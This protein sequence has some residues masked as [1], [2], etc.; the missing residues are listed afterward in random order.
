MKHSKLLLALALLAALGGGCKKKKD[1]NATSQPTGKPTT[2]QP[3]SVASNT[4]PVERDPALPKGLP[5]KLNKP[6]PNSQPT[7]PPEPPK[8]EPPKEP[9]KPAISQADLDASK[10]FTEEGYAALANLE[11][12]KALGLFDQALKKN[13]GNSDA[14]AG[15]GLAKRRAGDLPGAE[16]AFRAA[17]SQNSA[18][19]KALAGLVQV[20]VEQGQ[21]E[22]AVTA[23]Q[24]SVKRNPTDPE[25]LSILAGAEVSAGKLVDAQE[26]SRQALKFDERH[27]NARISLARAYLALTKDEIAIA[28]LQSARDINASNAAVW[29]YL[30]VA[31]MRLKKEVDALESFRK[32]TELD[33]NLPEA[34]ANYGARLIVVEDFN[35]AV[36]VLER[37]MLLSP[38][39]AIASLNLGSAYRGAG[40]FG[41]AENAYKKAIRL[42]PSLPEAYFNLAV[43]YLEH[44]VPSFD[45]NAVGRLEQSLAQFEAYKQAY[46]TALPKDDPTDAYIE[47]AQ[48][49]LKIEQKKKAKDPNKTLQTPTGTG[50]TPTGPSG[51]GKTGPT[52][53]SG[54]SGPSGSGTTTT[55][56]PTSTPSGPSG[57]G[58]KN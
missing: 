35:N 44:P 13:P 9:P 42:N 20:L 16:S 2:S 15:V 26:H 18:A 56:P 17:L 21:S 41:P 46:K 36:L 29:F 23:A 54:P 10:R 12:Q 19:S 38:K 11:E 3:T 47:L 33:R 28:V 58:K 49:Q 57:P 50:T 39:D 6:L 40:Q 5:D 52:G 34:F 8:P 27:I 14:Q 37:A 24:E 32:A 43:L 55:P 30:G 22:R 31:Q 7:K 4:P 25:L 53:P 48:R 1:K 51:P 45:G